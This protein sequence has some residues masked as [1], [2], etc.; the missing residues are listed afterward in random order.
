MRRTWLIASFCLLNAFGYFLQKKYQMNYSLAWIPACTR[1][2]GKLFLPAEKAHYLTPLSTSHGFEF[3]S[4]LRGEF[5]LGFFVIIF[6][7]SKIG[8]TSEV[9][10]Y[11]FCV[12]SFI[13]FY[14]KDSIGCKDRSSISEKIVLNHS[15][16]VVSFFWPRIREE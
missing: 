2:T 11:P 8:G 3:C 7:I 12:R 16:L 14:E 1:M 10:I 4:G 6:L 5:F 15:V 9:L 13:S